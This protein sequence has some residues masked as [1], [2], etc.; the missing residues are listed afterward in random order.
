MARGG[1]KKALKEPSKSTTKASTNT[2]SDAPASYFSPVHAGLSSFANTLPTDHVFIVHADTST[3]SLRRKVFLVPVLL[4]T[5]LSALLIWRFYYA[6]PEYLYQIL[7]IF[8]YQTS[9]TI[10]TQAMPAVDI[11]Q[12]IT[13]R[14]TYLMIDYFVFFVVGRWPYEFLFGNKYGRFIGAAGWKL[15]VG[16]SK[17]KEVVVRRGRGWDGPILASDTVRKQ[18]GKTD[19]TWTREEELRI[20]S[21]CRDALRKAY[22][23]KTSFLLL[24]KD[25]DLEFQGMIDADELIDEGKMSWSDID[26]LVLV[27]FAGDWFCWYPY[28][29]ENDK[30]TVVEPAI[31]AQD[32]RL[33]LL[34]QKLIA[35]DCED[36]FYRWIEILQYETSREGGFSDARK[37]AAVQEFQSMLQKRGKDGEAFWREVGSEQQLPGLD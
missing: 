21:K 5:V 36:L 4:N 20:Y 32:Q 6:A 33:D 8:G 15:A 26:H 14:T 28:A 13:T 16:F 18:Q 35:I 12:V 9:W 3:P 24:D 17:H 11:F 34:H 31:L 23:S 19:M 10:D 1:S 25:W 30:T 27:P 7:T 22:T 2:A 29:A 37:R